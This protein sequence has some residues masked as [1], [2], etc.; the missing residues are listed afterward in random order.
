RDKLR[1]KGL[2]LIVANDITQKDAGF[3]TDTNRVVILDRDGGEEALPLLTKE[4]VAHRILDRVV[5]L[6]VKG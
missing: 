5:K 1:R 3:A 2:H 6:M 4:Q